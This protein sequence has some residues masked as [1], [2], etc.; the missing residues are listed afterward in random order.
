MGKKLAR[1]NYFENRLQHTERIDQIWQWHCYLA[2]KNK[3][4]THAARY[5][6]GR[7]PLDV[8]VLTIQLGYASHTQLEFKIIGGTEAAVAETAAFWIGLEKAEEGSE[9]LFLFGSGEH[10]DFR[11]AGSHC[12]VQ[13]GAGHY[14]GNK[15]LSDKFEFW[16]CMSEDGG[17]AFVI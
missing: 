2:R 5:L 6:G 13:C 15:I 9:D 17:A 11:S 14:S 3:T 8:R 1:L 4:M 10:F 16:D 7:E 12:L